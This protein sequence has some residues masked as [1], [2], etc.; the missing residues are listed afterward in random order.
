M[1][2]SWIYVVLMVDCNLVFEHVYTQKCWFDS[3]VCSLL[4]LIMAIFLTLFHCISFWVWYLIFECLYPLG[5]RYLVFLWCFPKWKIRDCKSVCP[6][7]YMVHC[8]VFVMP[9]LVCGSASGD[10]LAHSM[11]MKSGISDNCST[12]SV[13]KSQLHRDRKSVV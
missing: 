12:L 7:V 4:V 6:Y 1:I 2:Y 10:S 13:W 11:F 5:I 3:L 8:S 9:Y